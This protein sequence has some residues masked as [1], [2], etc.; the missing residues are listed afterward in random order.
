MSNDVRDRWRLMG[1]AALFVLIA[2]L[3]ATDLLMD[4]G[5][6][7][8]FLHI[9]VESFA[10]FTAASGAILLLRRFSRA[11]SDLTVARSEANQ[12]REANRELVTGLGEAIQNQFAL[13]ELSAAEAEIGLFLLKGLSHQEIADLRQT[14]ERTV[15]EQARALYRKSGL[16]GRSALSAFFLEDLLPGMGPS[17]DAENGDRHESHVL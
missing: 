13:W 2:L 7:A 1:P 14:S 4:Q 10:L 5:E 11:R 17:T 15:R 16:S 9:A 12:W 8:G 3:I 6:G